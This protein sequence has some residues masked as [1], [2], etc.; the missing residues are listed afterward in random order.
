LVGEGLVGSRCF[1]AGRGDGG[2]FFPVHGG[3]GPGSG[4]GHVWRRPGGEVMLKALQAG[5]GQVQGGGAARVLSVSMHVLARR[6]R[7]PE[8]IWARD[9][10]PL[11]SSSST[12][13]VLGWR[14]RARWRAVALGPGQR[15]NGRGRSSSGWAT[16]PAWPCPSCPP[17]LLSIAMHHLGLE[18]TRGHNGVGWGRLG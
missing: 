14:R 7:R 17:P 10:R 8:L 12:V 18:G 4:R 3:S 9:L 13:E 5:P 6:E 2:I 15:C 1:Q 11:S 16:W